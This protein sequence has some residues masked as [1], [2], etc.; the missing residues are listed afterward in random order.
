MKKK[1]LSTITAAMLIFTLSS[2]LPDGLFNNFTVSA[3]SVT[4][5]SY[6]VT[7]LLAPFNNFFFVK[8]DNPDPC[9]FSFEDLSSK[10]A[11]VSDEENVKYFCGIS[12]TSYVF[13]DIEY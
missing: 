6:E 3:A 11:Q 4:D 13:E 12:A 1:L 9:S 2:V 8:T 5:Y 10:Y 7:P